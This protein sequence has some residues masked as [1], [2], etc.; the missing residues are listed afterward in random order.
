MEET[1]EVI[2]DIGWIYWEHEI[3]ED[4]LELLEIVLDLKKSKQKYPHIVNMKETGKSECWYEY[5][6]IEGKQCI[7]VKYRK[8]DIKNVI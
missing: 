6:I 2:K 5:P 4:N 8:Y 3:E 1:K 7:K